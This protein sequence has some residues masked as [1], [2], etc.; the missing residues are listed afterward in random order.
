MSFAS[1]PWLLLLVLVPLVILLHALSIRWRATPVSSLVFWNEVLKDRKS[2]MR[3]R[4]LLT[5]LVLLLQCLAVVTLAVAM[6][7][8]MIS[9]LGGGARSDVVLVLDATASMQV[10]EGAR[11]RFD[12]ARE[13]GLELAAGLQGGARMAVVL[14]E[15][16]PRLLSAF[17][18]DKGTLRRLL[19]VAAATDEPGDVA[20]SVVLALSLRDPRRGGQIVL[21]TDGAFDQLRGVDLTVPWIRVDVVG[22][23]RDNVGITRMSFRRTPG[24]G[25]SPGGTSVGAA[26]ELFLAVKNSGR[27]P[28]S[29]PV[30]VRAAGR[31]V[32]NR[33]LSLGAG[34]GSTVSAPWTGPVT[35]RVEAELQTGDPFPLD[36][37]AFAVFAPA[38]RV[39]VLVV[40]P[41]PWFILQALS[42]LPGVT[43]SVEDT[44]SAAPPAAPEPR[45]SSAAD[46]TIYVDVQPP[47]LEK[48][49]YILFAAAPPNFP[50]RVRGN[51]PVPPV[52]GW[53]RTNPLLESVSLAG[54]TIGQALDFDPGPGFSVLAASGMSPLLLSWDHAGVKALL[55]AFDP[56]ASDFPLR[57][58]FPILLANALSWFFPTWL[59]A[60]AD[61][62]QA[63]DTRVLPSG[64]DEGITVVKPDGRTVSVAATGAS[65]D[66]RDTD[67][68]GFYRVKSGETS[69]EF[70]V[71]LASDSETDITPRLTVPGG[72]PGGSGA[73]R[74]A[75]ASAWALFAGAA[76]ALIV[77]EWL[78]WLRAPAWRQAPTGRRS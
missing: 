9:G 31:E 42:S 50:L 32:I 21:E 3:L 23:A 12:I 46:V 51:L 8:P 7:R 15:K 77:L 36:D 70:A 73:S 53:S 54:M 72:S 33:T 24:G 26:Y 78:A 35:G 34:Q 10:R 56:R 38:R 28:V 11:T 60:Q 59:G 67:E 16:S 48:G 57:P 25:P 40:G 39:Q 52:T 45:G 61:A 29:V 27:S 1:P 20:D 44:P 66:F 22:S 17:T 49:N 43:V 6:A 63:G 74:N 75:A 19:A 47:P 2:S 64:N 18:G 58:G 71:N 5:S 37:R 68:T 4:R 41:Q 30:T 65:V 55:S 13:R 62:V 69:S 14:A 76:L